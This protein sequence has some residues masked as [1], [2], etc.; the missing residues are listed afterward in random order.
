MDIIASK[1]LG[2][3]ML[4]ERGVDGDLL[5][6]LGFRNPFKKTTIP[7]PSSGRPPMHQRKTVRDDL[8][9]LWPDQLRCSVA[10][11]TKRGKRHEREIGPD[12]GRQKSRIDC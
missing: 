12:S 6:E 4:I 11:R 7:K 9:K 2:T 5:Q 10:P 1:R 8:K 3:R